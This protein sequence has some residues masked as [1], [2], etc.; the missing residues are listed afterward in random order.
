M[1][2]PVAVVVARLRA[3]ETHWLPAIDYNGRAFSEFSAQ[4]VGSGDAGD[5]S[6]YDDDLH[7]ADDRRCLVL[8]RTGTS[9]IDLY[10]ILSK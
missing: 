5:T 6:P 9:D 8:L 10:K 1:R 7:F 3:R 2:P 4:V